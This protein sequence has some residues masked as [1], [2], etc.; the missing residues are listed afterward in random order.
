MLTITRTATR[1]LAEVSEL[2]TKLIENLVT[3]NDQIEFLVADSQSTAENVTGGNKQLK[4]ATERPSAARWT[5]YATGGLCSFL[6]LWD[7]IF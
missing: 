4:K 3:Q 5:F 2:Q 6:V 7:L 1:S